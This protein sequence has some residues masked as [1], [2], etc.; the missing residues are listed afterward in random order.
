MPLYYKSQQ[1]EEKKED[2]QIEM[3]Q[4]DIFQGSYPIQII[5]SLYLIPIETL[6][7]L[8]VGYLFCTNN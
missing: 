3:S 5:T 2:E 1:R 4:E 7:V 6:S 8:R